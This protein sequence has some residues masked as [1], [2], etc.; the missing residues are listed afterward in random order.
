MCLKLCSL[1]NDEYCCHSSSVPATWIT[2]P[3][4]SMWDF[5]SSVTYI[6]LSRSSEADNKPLADGSGMIKWPK[7]TEVLVY[8]ANRTF[9][10]P[11]YL[12]FKFQLQLDVSSD[13]YD[14]YDGASPNEVLEEYEQHR[15][16]W[17]INL[18]S[19]KH[20]T[21]KLN[22]FNQSCIGIYSSEGHEVHLNIISKFPQFFR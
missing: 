15:S 1:Y 21:I 3:R 22:P 6:L 9:L 10:C 11:Y 19:W 17:A 7:T 4:S 13:K 18:F 20:K 16:S 12:N 5:G 14:L 2:S 8:A